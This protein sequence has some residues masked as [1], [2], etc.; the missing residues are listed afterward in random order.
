MKER[1]RGNATQIHRINFAMGI[2]SVDLVKA[3]IISK[4]SNASRRSRFQ[5]ERRIVDP[6][7]CAG[8]AT[9]GNAA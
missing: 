2:L 5:W 1:A 7:F 6:V 9:E 8:G 3:L 4:A